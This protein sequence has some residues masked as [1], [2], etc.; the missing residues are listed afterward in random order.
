V[1]GRLDDD[2]AGARRG[3]RVLVGGDVVDGVG[4]RCAGVDLHWAHSLP[5]TLRCNAEVE[6][7][8]R[9]GDGGADLDDGGVV[10]VGG[11]IQRSSLSGTGRMRSLSAGFD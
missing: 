8:L 2:G 5:L 7:G 6:V 11:I 9:A 4:C 3:Q 1:V 10:T